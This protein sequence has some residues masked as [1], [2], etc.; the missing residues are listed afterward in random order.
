MSLRLA[1]AHRVAWI[2][3]QGKADE[4][5]QQATSTA[6]HT[7]LAR[8]NLSAWRLPRVPHSL[9]QGQNSVFNIAPGGRKPLCR[10]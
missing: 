8:C 2:G 1:A 10:V 5:V 3:L 7:C 6:S 9:R 4:S